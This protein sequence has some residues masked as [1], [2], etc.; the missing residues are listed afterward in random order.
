MV[1]VKG[2]SGR[3]KKDCCCVGCTERKAKKIMTPTQIAEFD[4][5]KKVEVEGCC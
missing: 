2:R 1:G 4:A 5:S 3:H